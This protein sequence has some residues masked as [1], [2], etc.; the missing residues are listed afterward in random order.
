MKLVNNRQRSPC[1]MRRPQLWGMA[2]GN[3]VPKSPTHGARTSGPFS[4]RFSAAARQIGRGINKRAFGE[5]QPDDYHR[6]DVRQP[7]RIR[8]MNDA[9]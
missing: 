5:T 4:G 8:I 3:L 9:S 7:P 2:S 6:R 1:A